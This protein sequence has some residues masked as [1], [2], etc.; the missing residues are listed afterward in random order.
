MFG[1][2]PSLLLC[3]ALLLL[4]G[5]TGCH[6]ASR[7]VTSPGIDAGSVW[8]N[9]SAWYQSQQ[10]VDDRKVDLFYLCST[11]VISARDSMGE[12]TYCSLLTPADRTAIRGEL[13]FA[14]QQF[15]GGDVNYFAPYYHQF[16]F[17]AIGLPSAQFTEVYRE[18]AQEVCDAFDY[19]M[20]YQNQGRR[21]VLMG[22]S[23]GAM[24]VLDLLRHMT[25]EQYQ[26]LVAAYSLGYRLSADDLA[27]PHIN[28]AQGETDTGVTISFNSEL[29]REALWPFVAADAATCINPVNWRTDAVPATFT[30]DSHEHQVRV[31]AETHTLL[32]ET[33][34]A[35]T[36]RQWTGNPV[37]RAA[38]V[39][40]DCLHHY[41]LLFYTGQ[42][43][44]NLLK[45]SSKVIDN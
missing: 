41:D 7:S 27:H 30:Y 5:L 3:S 25:D 35:D 15:G 29:R 8:V 37:F 2:L 9:D 18:V 12:T 26:R 40:P 10:A 24:L 38:G 34:H 32:V 28:A 31:D 14:E 33:D 45:R 36:Y 4:L 11:E 21:F 39:S 1:K 17:D 16:T 19:Y 20:N 6:T 42:I 22:F 43:H 13:A 23:Q 44:D